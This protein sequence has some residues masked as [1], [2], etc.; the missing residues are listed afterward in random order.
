MDGTLIFPGGYIPSL[1]EITPAIEKSGLIVT[2]LEVL[3]LHYAET[4]KAWRAR[5]LASRDKVA[6]LYD[7]RF[8]R[9][10]EFYLAACE[11]GFRYNGLVVFQFQLAKQVGTLPTSR[12]Y[13]AR[14]EQRLET[15]AR[16]GSTKSNISFGRFG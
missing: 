9:M 16:E 4:L 13:I 1:S 10:W 11:A 7:E 6:E 14:A 8:C 3:R 12:D 5:F 2:D 15:S